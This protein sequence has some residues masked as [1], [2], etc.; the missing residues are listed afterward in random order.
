[1]I[2]ATAKQEALEGGEISTQPVCRKR[3]WDSLG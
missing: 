2:R 3:Q 1:M